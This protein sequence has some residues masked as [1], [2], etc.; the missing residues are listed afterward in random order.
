MKRDR[1]SL[2]R[3]RAASE[4]DARLRFTLAEDSAASARKERVALA[5]ASK[6]SSYRK[7]MDKWNE[8]GVVIASDWEITEPEISPVGTPSPIPPSSFFNITI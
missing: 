4:A 5:N 7:I 2:S 1:L 6:I 8:S 3:E